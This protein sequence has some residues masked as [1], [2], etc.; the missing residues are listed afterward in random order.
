VVGVW[1]E[2]RRGGEVT[3]EQGTGDGDGG[4]EG[5]GVLEVL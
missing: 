3:L 5:G 2:W 4:V 1:W